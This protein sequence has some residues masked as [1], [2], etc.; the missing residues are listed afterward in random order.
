[1]HVE[2]EVEPETDEKFSLEKTKI[3]RDSPLVEH[4]RCFRLSS[5]LWHSVWTALLKS[6]RSSTSIVVHR[7][8]VSNARKL[9]LPGTC[10]AFRWIYHLTCAGRK[11]LWSGYHGNQV[12][13]CAGAMT[14]HIPWRRHGNREREAGRLA[15]VHRDTSE[16]NPQRL[17]GNWKEKTPKKKSLFHTQGQKCRFF[18]LNFPSVKNTLWWTTNIL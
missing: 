2:V 9:W 16:F 6:L 18:F 14:S 13:E 12:R 15:G 1:M 4:V 17:E 11:L 7:S 3:S 5:S 10:E 8:W